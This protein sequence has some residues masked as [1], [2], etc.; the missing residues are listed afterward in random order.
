[1]MIRL[2]GFLLI[3]LLNTCGN[4]VAEKETFWVSGKKVTCTGVGEQECMLISY[5]DEPGEWENFYTSIDGFEF[6]PGVMQKITV[7]RTEKENVPAN[8][9]KYNYELIEVVESKEMVTSST[10]LNDIW[11]LNTLMGTSYQE[12]EGERPTFKYSKADSRVGGTTGCNNYFGDVKSVSNSTIEFGQLASTKKACAGN[13]AEQEFLN[14][15]NEV[16]SYKIA[17]MELSFYNE[18]GDKIAEFQKVD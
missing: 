14:M 16:S 7:Q 12:Y 17:N 6:K 5:E 10:K 8:A 1:M 9:S 13:H 4:N 15:M 18:Q 11:A 3:A 2:L